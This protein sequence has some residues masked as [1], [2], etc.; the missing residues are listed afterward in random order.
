MDADSKLIVPKVDDVISAS[1]G[2]SYPDHPGNIAFIKKIIDTTEIYERSS[3]RDRGKINQDIVN[4]FIDSGSR[5]LVKTKENKWEESSSKD[6][7]DKVGHAFRK[8]LLKKRPRITSTHEEHR[9]DGHI[10]DNS[11]RETIIEPI[12]CVIQP[13]FPTQLHH[14]SSQ[15]LQPPQQ[16]QH[17]E[18]QRRCHQQQ[19]SLLQYSIDGYSKV[20]QI[21]KDPSI[22]TKGSKLFHTTVDD[23]HQVHEEQE[24]SDANIDIDLKTM[25]NPFLRLMNVFYTESHSKNPISDFV[26]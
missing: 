20:P 4:E 21:K 13:F 14:T 2:K 25:C 12:E 7:R 5:F 26:S 19:N 8:Q 9:H 18:G 24:Q 17:P 3:K 6:A 10:D 16:P 23:L 15:Q 22:T 1:N 11:G